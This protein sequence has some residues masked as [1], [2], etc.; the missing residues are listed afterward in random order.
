VT[1]LD[2]EVVL[3]DVLQVAREL[4]G[5]R[6]AA[7]GILDDERR[8]LERFL[9][10][11][12]DEHTREEIGAL[13]RGRGVL[14]V[15][16]TDP[17]P[18]RLSDVGSHPRSYGF[19][20]AH[21]PMETF[22]GVPLVIRGE[23]WG[24]LYL[25]EKEGGEP[26]TDEDE[27][28]AVVLA[29]WASIAVQNARL[30]QTIEGRRVDLE[31]AVRGLE[32]T[33]EISVALGGETQLPRVL[34]LIAKRARALVEAR[35]LIILLQEDEDLEV[36]V[37]VGELNAT[38]VGARV[39]MN[40]SLAGEVLARGRPKRRDR[41]EPPSP[42]PGQ[43]ETAETS[44]HVP[45]VFRGRGLGVIIAYDRLIEGPNFRQED[46]VLLSAF[47]AS[48]A[49]AVHAARSVAEESLRHA[50]EAAEQ[51]RRRWA[52]EL[53]DETLQGL[54]GLHALLTSALST[55]DPARIEAAVREAVDHAKV[56]IQ[57]LRSLITELRPAALDELGLEPA[58]ES[59]AERTRMLQGVEVESAIAIGD[60]RLPPEL[61]ST[62]YRVV[63]ESLTN[64][65]KHAEASRITIRITADAGA[66]TVAVS[67]D[68]KGFDPAQ[69]T[70][71]FGL[72][73]MRERLELLGGSAEIKTARERGT[74]V[75]ATIP[76]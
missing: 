63:Q 22:L 52:R 31:R 55:G 60:G 46:E 1:E 23:A 70:A 74:T 11:G 45:L 26:F 13:P 35:A 73:G 41:G 7:L 62:I 6:Y 49:T 10:S 5:A 38:T 18:L 44:L 17:R 47:A 36:A 29:N 2:P 59:L 75:T 54:G 15:L 68:G 14:G 21:P 42:L 66:V 4:T 58:L 56:E 40:N 67:D 3:H 69:H 30:H 28:S 25:T 27:A 57:S 20:P 9:T 50:L 61:E 34:E 76:L 39:P 12:M 64:A 72:R 19:P 43:F 33:T 37:A 16:T 71:G 48:G 24:N 32:A 53:H 65:A 8:E 51:E